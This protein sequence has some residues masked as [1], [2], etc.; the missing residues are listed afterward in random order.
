MSSLR[1]S[2]VRRAVELG[3]LR[4]E[5]LD[6]TAM[7]RSALDRAALEHV[8]LPGIEL[9]QPRREQ[10]LDRRRNGDLV[11]ARLLQQRDHLLDEQRVAF[12]GL[13]DPGAEALVQLAQ[14]LDQQRR[15]GSARAA[16]AAPSSR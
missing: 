11:V 15:L 10:R 5:R 13:L 16:R 2:E 14:A 12:G 1:T 6:G 3:L 7:E 8:P 9:I 4:V